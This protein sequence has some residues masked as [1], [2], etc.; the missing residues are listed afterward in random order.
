MKDPTE[1]AA[2]GGFSGSRAA[3]GILYDEIGERVYHLALRM[4]RDP[5]LA[6][7]V[8]HDAFVRAYERR[9]QFDGRGSLRGW[10]YAIAK[11]IAR[12]H[13]R[14]R[15]SRLEILEDGGTRLP[16]AT[17]TGT[18]SKS[19]VELRV[20]L[21]EAVGRLSEEHRSVLLLHE[22]DGYTHPEIG[23]ML[24]LAPGSCRARLSKARAQLRRWLA[25]GELDRDDEG[26]GNDSA[27]RDGR[28]AGS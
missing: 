12:D 5:T 9:D 8:T 7:D 11:N 14:R 13:L 25:D 6:E 17:G 2:T 19:N 16:A 10:V 4:T 23:E 1:G 26:L 21:E 3:W 20:I 27:E 22:V 18:R 28:P 15:A 24:G